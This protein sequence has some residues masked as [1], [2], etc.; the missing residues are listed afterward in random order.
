MSDETATTGEGGD[1]AYERRYMQ[2]GERVVWRE[3]VVSRG[4]SVA[5]VIFGVVFGGLG[6][7]LAGAAALGALPLPLLAP[8]LASLALGV[9]MAVAGVAFSVFRSMVT[10]SHAHVHFGWARRKI[11]MEAIEVV[12]AVT[13][14]GYHQGKVSIGLDGTV[15]SWAGNASSGRGV[16]IAYREGTRRHVLTVGSEDPDGFVRAIE[17]GQGFAGARARFA[18]AP[19]QAAVEPRTEEEAIADAQAANEEERAR[20]LRAMA[21]RLR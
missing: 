15:R 16:E 11:P 19:Q 18:E 10:P 21:E 5:S 7:A 1:D 4:A 14:R 3:K 6:L 2:P 20:T 13:I 9:F 17:A 12:S 8:G